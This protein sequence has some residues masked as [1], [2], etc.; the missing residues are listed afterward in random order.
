MICIQHSTLILPDHYVRNGTLVLDRNTITY[1]GAHIDTPAGAEEI[2]GEGLFTGPGLIDIHLHAGNKVKFIDECT[3]PARFHLEHGTTSLMPTLYFT[4]TVEAAVE[5]INYIKKYINSE[6]APNIRGMYFEGPYMNPEFGAS[7][8][9][10]KWGGE[11]RREDYMP[12]LEAAGT[13]IKVWGVAPEREH[14]EM[15]CADAK[16]INPNC[17]FSTAHCNCT[18]EQVERLFPYGLRLSTH[19]TNATGNQPHFPEC[20]SAGVDEAV[21]YYGDMY[22]EMIS[23]EYG[24]HVQPFMQRYIRRIKG[25]DRLILITDQGYH[26]GPPLPGLEHVKDIYFDNDGEIGASNITLDEACRN[27]MTHTGASL[28]DAFYAASYNPAKLLGWNT[29]GHLFV[30][31]DADVI[32]VDYDM[33]VKKVICNGKIEK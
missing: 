30:G 6:E 23:D 12:V 31:G 2:N 18:P 17:V 8:R 19:H 10:I 15:F 3:Q 16:K 32:L 33:N 7:K 27:Y 21:N 20:R 24:V 13:D 25:R 28:C 9:E 11:I 29:K 1:C 5:K 26:V 4:L 22:A 14:I